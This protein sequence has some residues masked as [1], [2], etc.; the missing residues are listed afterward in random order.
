MVTYTLGFGHNLGDPILAAAEQE[1][2]R[3]L[4]HF[5]DRG[6]EGRFLSIA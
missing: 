4:R 2:P 5:L 1:L 6:T 3:A